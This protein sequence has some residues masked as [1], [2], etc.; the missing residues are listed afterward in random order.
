[1]ETR[2]ILNLGY[3]MSLWSWGVGQLQGGG[4]WDNPL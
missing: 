2:G 1:M 3:Y 4:G